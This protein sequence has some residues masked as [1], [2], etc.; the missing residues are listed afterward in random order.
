MTKARKG[1]GLLAGCLLLW[2]GTASVWGAPAATDILRFRPKQ[3]GIN[4]STPSAQ[5]QAG[6]AVELVKGAKPGTSGWLVRDARGQALRQ[7]FDTNGDKNI[8]VYSYYLDGAEVYREID[9]NFDQKIDQYRWLNTGGMKWGVD[10]NQ[11]GKID[12]WKAISPEEVSQEIV[13]ALVAKD[14]NRLQALWLTDAEAKALDL[15]AA[16]AARIQEQQKQAYAKFQALIAKLTS[17]GEKTHWVRLETGA[18]QCQLAETAGGKPGATQDVVR[19]PRGLILYETAGKSEWLQAGEMIQVGLAWRITEAPAP[20]EGQETA[21]MPALNPELQALLERLRDHDKNPPKA[22]GAPGTNPDAVRYNVKRADLIELIVAKVKPEER[23]P[24]IRQVADCLSA[25]AQNSTEADKVAYER[26]TRLEDQL[27]KAL[28]GSNL[29][30]YVTFREMTAEYAAKLAKPGPDIAKVQDHWLE[31]LAKFVQTYPKAEDTPDALLQLGMVSE[32]VGKEAESKKWYDLLVKNFAEHPL[33]GKARGSLRRLELEGKPLEL[34]GPTLQGSPFTIAGVRGKVVVVYY[35]ASWNQQCLGDFAKLKLLLNTYG[36]KGLELVCV[37][38]DNTAEEAAGFLQRAPAPGVHL[39]QPG[40]L[41]SP[42]AT[43][44]G[45]MV[46]P[47]LFLT[48]KD[49]KVVSRTVQMSN[50]EDEIKKL[51]K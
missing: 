6:C 16:D 50:L 27:V 23:E 10:V 35:W 9:S 28:P 14:F 17:L 46:L 34:A 30:A 43:H 51:L 24:W 45:V 44:Y 22:E 18:P 12:S 42:L 2:G 36:S 29:A 21:G 5:E 38:L 11:D 41:E 31:R 25:A 48:D 47:N 33:T 32:F 13:Q 7:F 20:G 26:L 40:G 4:Y 15:P 37:N 1:T 3:D 39:F 19:H 8:D 49:G